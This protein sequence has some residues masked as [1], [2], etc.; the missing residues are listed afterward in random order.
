MAN[1]LEK[2]EK[3]A[4]EDNDL[5]KSSYWKDKLLDY[6][7]DF[8]LD[9]L[10]DLNYSSCFT[11]LISLDELKHSLFSK[12]VDFLLES[13][14]LYFLEILISTQKPL[15]SFHFWK[16][17]RK[18]NGIDRGFITSEEV[19][20]EKHGFLCKKIGTFIGENKLLLLKNNDLKTQVFLEGRPV[21]FYY[22]FFNQEGEDP[23]KLPY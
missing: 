17:L 1:I 14:D 4:Y 12:E 10:T 8:Y 3:I 2:I 18:E 5:K 16:Y 9:D 23:L 11:Y 20:L 7:G 6:F 19:Y 15:V 21:S 22:K 13:S